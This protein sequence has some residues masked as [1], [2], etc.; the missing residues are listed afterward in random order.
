MVPFAELLNHECSDVYYTMY[1]EPENPHNPK[2][3]FYEEKELTEEE[4]QELDTSD[5]TY[6]SEEFDDEE[7]RWEHGEEEEKGKE[8]EVTQEEIEKMVRDTRNYLW[9]FVN[10]GDNVS[11][12]YLLETY[13][14]LDTVRTAD[15]S[16]PLKKIEISRIQ[17]NN[18][19]YLNLVKWFHSKI[20]SSAYATSTFA[21]RK[22]KEKA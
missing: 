11:L 5:G 2:E 18:S 7:L 19:L 4:I 1:Y 22:P 8:P 13:E 14:A 20:K 9:N 21:Q 17:G 3:E 10:F 15:I 6:N 12:G 16:L